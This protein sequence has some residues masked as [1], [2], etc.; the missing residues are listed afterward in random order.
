M[1]NIFFSPLKLA[2]AQGLCFTLTPIGSRTV[3]KIYKKHD[4]N[5]DVCLQILLFGMKLVCVCNQFHLSSS[6]LTMIQPF[7]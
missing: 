5:Q 1:I 7:V 6:V 4:K 3:G 2:M